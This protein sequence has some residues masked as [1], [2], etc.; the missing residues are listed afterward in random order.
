MTYLIKCDW[1]DLGGGRVSI[2]IDSHFTS[3]NTACNWYKDD[4]YIASNPRN[5]PWFE[6]TFSSFSR[7]S[8]IASQVSLCT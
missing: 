8:V 7:T 5:Y 1:R 6:V 3:V 4:P 2:H